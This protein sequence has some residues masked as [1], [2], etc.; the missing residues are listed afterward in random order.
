M[1]GLGCGWGS[2]WSD[3]RINSSS[4]SP[5]GSGH[6]SDST[7]ALSIRKTRDFTLS[8]Q[9][10]N[11]SF[12]PVGPVPLLPELELG[13]TILPWYYTTCP[14]GI[15]LKLRRPPVQRQ[16]F[17]VNIQVEHLKKGDKI[18]RDKSA[19]YFLSLRKTEDGTQWHMETIE[20]L[21]RKLRKFEIGLRT[22]VSGVAVDYRTVDIVDFEMDSEGGMLL[23]YL[24]DDTTMAWTRVEG[25]MEAAAAGL[26]QTLHDLKAEKGKEG[27]RSS[28]D[29]DPLMTLW[30]T[31][32]ACMPDIFM[33]NSWTIPKTC[34]LY[35]IDTL[36]VARH[37]WD[38]K[39]RYFCTK[40]RKGDDVMSVRT[41]DLRRLRRGHGIS[42]PCSHCNFP[43]RNRAS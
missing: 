34:A 2:S 1:G 10:L 41:T 4:A 12:I 16:D 39:Y 6:D 24:I 42:N 26:G 27:R 23:R 22:L 37:G 19:H 36:S 9:V 21:T 18:L 28:N 43:G 5:N 30:G 29:R 35:R 38:S 8:E 32:C 20:M 14:T 13:S 15:N 33:M 17:I 40:A 7:D 3:G 25:N 11:L 31:V